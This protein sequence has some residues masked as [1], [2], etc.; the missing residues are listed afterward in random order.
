M[1]K[2]LSEV[3]RFSALCE[4]VQH[5][6]N[7]TDAHHAA[8]YTLCVYL[9]KMREYFRWENG[10]GFS[11]SLPSK[12]VGDWLSG[13]EKL[14]RDI[15]AESY[16][17]LTVGQHDFSPF[18]T[19]AV[20]RALIPQGYVYSGGIGPKTV[21]HFFLGSL[22]AEKRYRGYRILISDSECA[23]DIAAPPAMCLG[24]TI[25]I[26]RESLKRMLWEKFTD[27]RWNRAPGLIQKS[28]GFY[29][30]ENALEQSLE[31]MCETETATL[32]LHEIGEVMA[33]RRIGSGWQQ[34]LTALSG[35]AAET[36]AR[37]VKD[38]L[39]DMLSTLP[40]LLRQRK[41]PSLYFYAA[42]QT[43][44]R[45]HLFPMLIDT[46]KRWSKSNDF[47]YWQDLPTRAARHW[48]D[49]AQTM[50]QV[51]HAQGDK[52]ASEITRLAEARIL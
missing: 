17:R 2:K 47:A 4:T 38:H 43:P 36:A 9:L 22:S 27:W 11:D 30:F 35:S 20:N 23:R 41:I 25:F 33:S 7:I 46:A 14:W 13:R 39:A 40:E 6:C 45:R 51:F 26:R 21:P 12:K 42:N 48:L 31:Q 37:A 24:S 19:E 32:I 18:D 5:N 50:L 16:S 34:M 49:A 8:N 10:Y 15:E 52:A 28:F 44:M 29:D 1:V 3:P